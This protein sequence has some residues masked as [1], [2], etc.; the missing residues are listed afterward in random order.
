MLAEEAEFWWMNACR[1][2]EV[3]GVV[4]SWAMFK[5][6]FLRKYFSA[7]VRNKKEI[8]F[9]GVK[10][11]SMSIV[12]YKAKFEVLSRFYP[13][14]NAKGAEESKCIKFERVLHP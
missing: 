6:E 7:D 2:L 14:I 10:Q 13:Y 3:V 11:G 9:L 1:R 4:V 5:E 8:E 12:E